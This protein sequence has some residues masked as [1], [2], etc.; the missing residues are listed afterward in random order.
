MPNSSATCVA[1]LPLVSHSSTA[2]CL[3]ATS[4]FFF[5]ELLLRYLGFDH[6]LNH[7]RFVHLRL[8]LPVSVESGQPQDRIGES[9]GEILKRERLGGLLKFYYREAA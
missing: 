7:T 3:K 6:R 9:S 1:D 5:V 8:S 4:N 2:R